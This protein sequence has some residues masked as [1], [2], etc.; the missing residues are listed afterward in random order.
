MKGIIPIRFYGPEI[1][2]VI[3]RLRCCHGFKGVKAHALIATGAG[4]VNDRL[5]Q[6]PSNF[7]VAIGG[8]DVKPFHF[9]YPFFQ[10][11]QG[12]ATHNFFF[13]FSQKNT[14]FGRRIRSGKRRQLAAESLKFKIKTQIVRIL[15][16]QL[17]CP[18]ILTFAL[19]VDNSDHHRLV[20]IK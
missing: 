13:T 7:S 10:G 6:R 18:S 3:E 5:G 12:H 17:A 16:K 8:D 19:G 15:L 2:R 11:A 1:Q 4:P 14:A 20:V 9:A